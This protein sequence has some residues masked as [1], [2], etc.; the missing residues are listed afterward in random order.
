M[1]RT[2]ALLGCFVA[3]A[4]ALGGCGGAVSAH[5]QASSEPARGQ[6]PTV[7]FRGGSL[8]G[9]VY[10]GVGVDNFIDLDLYRLAGPLSHAQRLTFSPIDIGIVSATANRGEVVLER[11]CCGGLHFLDEL[12]LARPGGLPGTIIGAGTDADIARDGRFER[13]VSGYQGCACDALVVRPSLFGPDHAQYTIRWPGTIIAAGWSPTGQLSAVVAVLL[14]S[15]AVQHPVILLDPG[16]S[17]QRR[18]DPGPKWATDAGYWF[19]PRG[20]LSWQLQNGAV[21]IRSPGGQ[22]RKVPVL[23]SWEV[24]CWLPNGTLFATSPFNHGIGTLDP[25][26]GAV[27]MIG[28]TTT[29]VAIV[30]FEC[31]LPG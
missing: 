20:Q 12:N 28:R 2:F 19:G 11:I 6:Q 22:L 5:K 10:A 29:D 1:P 23:G 16:T 17:R 31:P 13:V 15:G 14:R 3:A 25:R 24:T 7:I 8:P 27:T 26:T 21:M 9:T 18:I 30:P 4:L